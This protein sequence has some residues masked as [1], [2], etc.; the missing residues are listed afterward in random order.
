MTRD[1]S[2]HG[3]YFYTQNPLPK[4]TRI[5]IGLILEIN[6]SMPADEKGHFFLEFT[7]HVIRAEE[8]GMAVSFDRN[9]Q[10]IPIKFPS[11]SG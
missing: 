8:D 3:G 7:G 4:D 1:L 2:G 6:K 5:K 11:K 9:Y 10:H